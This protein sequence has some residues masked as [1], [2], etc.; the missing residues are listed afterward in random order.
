M[1]AKITEQGQETVIINLHCS[2]NLINAPIM[3][4][5]SFD[6]SSTTPR[7]DCSLFRQYHWLCESNLIVL[8]ADFFV[9]V[10]TVILLYVNTCEGYDRSLI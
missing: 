7:N 2:V 8:L 1:T 6:S 4:E 10:N 9:L 3:N 5:K